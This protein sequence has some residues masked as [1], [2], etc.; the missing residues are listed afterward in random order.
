MCVVVRCGG[1]GGGGRSLVHADKV[2]PV[3]A[4]LYADALSAS[5]FR[6]QCGAG[7]NL[8]SSTMSFDL[9]LSDSDEEDLEQW[10]KRRG[11]LEDSE[12][13]GGDATGSLPV[14]A[15]A[16]AAHTMPD[17]DEEEE[18]EIDWEDADTKPAAMDTL[19]PVTVDIGEEKKEERPKKKRKLRRSRFRYESL[20]RHVQ[21]LLQNLHH[22]HLLA[23][24]SRLVYMSAIAGDERVVALAHSLVPLH[25]STHG[26]EE[27]PCRRT[28]QELLDWFVNLVDHVEDR[29]AAQ[30]RRNLAAGAPRQH[31]RHGLRES[32]KHGKVQALESSTKDQDVMSV[33]RLINYID[34]LSPVF[35]EDPQLAPSNATS[36]NQLDKTLLFVALTRSLGWRVRVVG[37]LDPISPDLDVNHPLL[38]ECHN[39]FRFMVEQQSTKS[40]TRA[41]E[42]IDDSKLPAA[43]MVW[44]EVLVRVKTKRRWMHVDPVHHLLDR[45]DQVEEFLSEGRSSHR[46]SIVDALGVEHCTDRYRLTDVTPRY[47]QSYVATLRRRGIRGKRVDLDAQ[48]QQSWWAQTI[49]RLSGV[50]EP[51]KVEPSGKSPSE[52]I[53]LEEESDSDKKPA[54]VDTDDEID[55][56]EAMELQKSAEDEAIPTSKAAFQTHPVY[57]IAS[58]LGKAEVLALDAKQRMC[59]VF[60]GELVY[61][62][63]D[64]S[65][66]LPAHKWLYQRRKV[67][68]SELGKPIKRVKARKKPVAKNFK[69]LK[70][71]G[72]GK[73]NTGSEEQRAQEIAMAEKPL[74]D[75]MEDLYAIWQTDEWHPAPVGPS[76][77]IPVNQYNNIELELLNPGLV[78]I[79]ERGVAKIAKELG[80]PYAPCLL[81]FEGHGGNRTPDIRGIVVHAGNEQIVKVAAAQVLHHSI[82]EEEAQRRKAIE[83]RWRKL[84]V[85]LLTKDRVERE[86]G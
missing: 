86:Y 50:V 14:A 79:D 54:A 58:V 72:V 66:A 19:K 16:T 59:G 49:R 83:R 23:L 61:R 35:D 63:S 41:A 15:A 8:C 9:N 85:G 82:E 48:V 43:P 77:P 62:R 64:V 65:T 4:R 46:R 18:E 39:F 53:V 70:S 20:P 29:R 76:D 22:S 55:Q 27:T 5:S 38:S 42:S 44:A 36:W 6:P 78:H 26:S 71:Y 24:T 84:M 28:V 30:T 21:S 33:S 3:T 60:K 68:P 40:K 45:P 10:T 25:W 80:I 32:K 1:G 31:G 81:G 52:A 47:A 2:T 51:T 73:G 67:R 56:H 69:A 37:D 17:D 75:G 12:E 34:Y 11:F 7:R 13:D 74:D 57:V